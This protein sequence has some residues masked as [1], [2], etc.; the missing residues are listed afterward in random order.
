MRIYAK[1]SD[2]QLTLTHI[3]V[4]MQLKKMRIYA[5]ISGVKDAN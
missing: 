3:F 2:G 1:I 4:I 5:K